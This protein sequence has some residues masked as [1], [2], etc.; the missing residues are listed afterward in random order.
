[1]VQFVSCDVIVRSQHLERV[2]NSTVPGIGHL[3]TWK[4][5]H[6]TRNEVGCVAEYTEEDMNKLRLPQSCPLSK[7]CAV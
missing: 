7:V 3:F 6:K 5:W 4:T 1:V 2:D